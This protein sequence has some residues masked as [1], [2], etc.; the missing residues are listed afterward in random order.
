MKLKQYCRY[1]MDFSGKWSGVCAGFMGL[2]FFLR[3]FYYFGMINLQDH[4][5]G[6]LFI[7]LILPLVLCGAFM[8]LFSAVK[9]NAPGVYAIIG[10]VFCLM[11]MIW[12]FSSGDVLRILLSVLGYVAVGVLLVGTA[13]GYLPTTLPAAVLIAL[14]LIIRIFAYSIDCSGIGEYVMEFSE[15]GILVS[16]LGCVKSMKPH[17]K[18]E[19]VKE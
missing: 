13:G 3:I 9:W 12:N 4:D 10:C 5:S 1:K 11:L 7:Q 19:E 2:S 8:I 16:L 17:V 6:G 15:V 14:M 18:A